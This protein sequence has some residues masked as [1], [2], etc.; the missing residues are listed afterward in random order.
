MCHR[1]DN[2]HTTERRKDRNREEA[3]HYGGRARSFDGE[4]GNESGETLRPSVKEID[5][6]PD[7]E[8]T[9]EISQKD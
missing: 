5:P 6:I 1:T 9:V 7:L 3:P 2:E 4:F 8:A